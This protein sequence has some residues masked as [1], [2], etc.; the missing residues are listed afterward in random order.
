MHPCSHAL[1]GVSVKIELEV[2]KKLKL[3][4]VEKYKL[5]GDENCI[6]VDHKNIVKVVELND[7]IYID[8]GLIS[9][10]VIGKGSKHITTGEV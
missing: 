9:L 3:S 4:T 5:C 6:Y 8:D 2:G 1:Q 10:E 7:T